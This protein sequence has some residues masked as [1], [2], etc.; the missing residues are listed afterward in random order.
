MLYYCFS[1]YY[2]VLWSGINKKKSKTFPA[3]VIF[4]ILQF[5]GLLLISLTSITFVSVLLPFL[6]QNLAMWLFY[7]RIRKYLLPAKWLCKFLAF[8]SVDILLINW[9]KMFSKLQSF[10]W[11][12]KNFWCFTKFFFHQKWNSARLLLTNT[13]YTSCLTSCQTNQDL[14]S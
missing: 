7:V 14:G 10:S 8:F 11:Y 13:V 4:K 3:I 2:C 6:W 5:E 9:S 1:C 12:F